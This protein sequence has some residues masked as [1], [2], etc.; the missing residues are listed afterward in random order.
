M[1]LA[2]EVHGFLLSTNPPTWWR[3]DD[4]FIILS[5]AK[6]SITPPQ[7]DSTSKYANE[8]LFSVLYVTCTEYILTFSTD[9]PQNNHVKYR[10]SYNDH[11][12]NNY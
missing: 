12:H 2:C 11:N 5:S 1:V 6:Y 9:G 7:L 3:G 4:I 10:F 8:V